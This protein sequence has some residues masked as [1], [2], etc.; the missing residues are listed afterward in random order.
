MKKVIIM[1]KDEL[2]LVPHKSGC[3]KMYDYKDE[4]IYVG[5]SKNL[6]NRLK[7]YFTGRVTGKTRALVEEIRRFEYIVTTSEEEALILENDISPPDAP[8]SPPM[9]VFVPEIFIPERVKS[10][11][12]VL[13]LAEP[14][15]PP[16]Q[17]FPEAVMLEALILEKVHL[18]LV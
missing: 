1:F 18:L 5:K 13:L 3:Y 9:L 7:S 15:I 10:L 12:E 8:T 11:P 17:V 4:I 14:I 2:S 6:H 16:I